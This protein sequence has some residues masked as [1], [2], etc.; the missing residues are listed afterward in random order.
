M[1]KTRKKPSETIK[2]GRWGC[3]LDPSTGNH[4]I[5]FVQFVLSRELNVRCQ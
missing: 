1:R 2:Q 5:Y 3:A 4:T